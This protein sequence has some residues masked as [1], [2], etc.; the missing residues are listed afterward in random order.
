MRQGRLKVVS[1]QLDP[2][3]CSHLHLDPSMCSHQAQTP[4]GRELG[5]GVTCPTLWDAV[6][7]AQTRAAHAPAPAWQDRL[8]LRQVCPRQCAIQTFQ[9]C[10]HRLLSKCLLAIGKRLLPGKQRYAQGE[11]KQDG[12]VCASAFSQSRI[13]H[14][15]SGIGS[16]K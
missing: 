12:P 11:Q 14:D 16:A 13:G 4:W 6:P 1:Q 2:S 15:K 10:H 7:P 3:M 8:L 5:L 9:R